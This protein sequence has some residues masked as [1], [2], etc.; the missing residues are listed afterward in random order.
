MTPAGRS[1]NGMAPALLPR[2]MTILARHMWHTCGALRRRAPQRVRAPGR[3][4]GAV[5]VGGVGSK[6]QRRQCRAPLAHARAQ[7]TRP[8]TNTGLRVPT[9]TR[10]SGCVWHDGKMI[11]VNPAVFMFCPKFIGINGFRGSWL[12]V[13]GQGCKKEKLFLPGP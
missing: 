13:W 9:P 8:H 7:L 11:H 5:L 6:R 12:V 2:P 10:S 4:L 3:R 1:G